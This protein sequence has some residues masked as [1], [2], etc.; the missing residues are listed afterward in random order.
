MVI[1][2]MIQYNKNPSNRNKTHNTTT[3]N[4]LKFLWEAMYFFFIF[5]TFSNF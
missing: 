4:I 2:A 3:R 1:A 5:K